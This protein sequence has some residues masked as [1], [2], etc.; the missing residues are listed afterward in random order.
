MVTATLLGLLINI[1]KIFN[2]YGINTFVH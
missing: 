1:H 2:L